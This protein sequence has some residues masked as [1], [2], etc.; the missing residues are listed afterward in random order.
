MALS[1]RPAAAP[2]PATP[3]PPQMWI[4][5]HTHWD[6]EWYEPHDVFRARLVTVVDAVLD[7]LEA[8]EDFAFTLDGQTAAVRDYLEIRP[9]N[10]G[11]LRDA[12]A[13]GQLDIGP[14]DILLDEFCC[15]GETI[16]RNLELGIRSARRYGGEMRV[17][18]LPDMFG[19]AAQMPQILR[20]FGMGDASLWRGVPGGVDRDAFVWRS[21]DG[22][23]VRVEYLWDGYGSA[24]PLFEPVE[25]L[26]QQ[27]GAYL[28]ATR[29]RCAG[30]PPAGMYGTDHMAPRA[31]LARIVR[32]HN[33]DHP[34]QEL[35]LATLGQVVASRDHSDEALSA[36]PVVAGEMR[37]HALGNILPGVLSVRT[38]IKAAMARAER[39]LT[40]AERLDVWAGG[41]SRTAL[42]ERGWG[43]VVESSAHDSVTGCGSDATADEVESRL[44]IASNT[45]RGALDSALPRLAA[46][47]PKGSLAVFNPSAW[48]RPVLVEAV[49]E[50]APEDLPSGVQLVEEL[51][52][53]VRDEVL[54]D[55]ALP[56]VRRRIHGREY[57]GAQ[58][59]GYAFTGRRELTISVGDESDVP[60]DLAVFM[61]ALEDHRR[62]TA[63][64]DPADSAADMSWRILTLAP[65]RCRVLVGG[66][67]PGMGRLV[68]DPMSAAL[69]RHTVRM[70]D[71]RLS[72]GLVE[73]S[74]DEGGGVEV[75]DLTTGRHLTDALRIVDEGDRG[76]SY[77]FGPVAEPPVVDPVDVRVAIG[78]SGPLRGRILLTRTYSLPTGLAEGDRSRRAADRRDQEV[79]LLLELRADEPFLRVAFT[80][81]NGVRDHRMRLLVPTTGGDLPG[82]V[83]VGQYALTRRTRT[84]EGGWGE[85]PL[86]TYPASRL[87][88]AGGVAVLTDRLMEYE[89]VSAVPSARPA[90]AGAVRVGP[91]PVDPDPAGAAPDCLALTMLRAVGMMSVNDHPLRDEPAGSEV[92]VPGAQYVGRRVRTDLALDLSGSDEADPLLLRHSDAFRL[93]PVAVRG[94]AT[95]ASAPVPPDGSDSVPPDGLGPVRTWGEVVLESLRRT[96]DGIEARFVNYADRPRPLDA[97]LR[98]APGERWRRTDL[99]GTT[100]DEGQIVAEGATPTVPAATILTLR[101]ALPRVGAATNPGGAERPD[102]TDTAQ[103][104]R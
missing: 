65:R 27:I 96:G 86:P 66:T 47:A 16:V 12:V 70:S 51:P 1:T 53:V 38:G 5:P 94:T 17:G 78:E 102:P 29:E 28:T 64:A 89:V 23:D 22:S 57:L 80:Q 54:A 25:T 9:E 104:I 84:S 15:D 75:V 72:N 13:R 14:F 4:L 42:L 95:A 48:E 73:V 52:T 58:I 45:A 83:S 99:T 7:L 97:A 59:R 93:E 98:A 39:A 43:L 41:P 100:L 56:L 61:D 67:A 10:E 3:A 90:A 19:H 50:C 63:S 91:G 6:R 92:L 18:Y 101:R 33:R 55:D 26:S 81:T 44:D 40:V 30:Q 31:D 71:G 88:G 87:V 24:L 2:G 69:P 103:E 8:D 77:N 35:R 46:S 74:V 34:G 49:L 20:G 85:A 60:F 68:V 79:R 36:L 32:A 21:P 82:S 76:D 62:R 37:S 11:R